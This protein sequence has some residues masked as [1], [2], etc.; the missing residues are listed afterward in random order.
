MLFF[1][2]EGVENIIGNGENAGYQ[3]LFLSSQCF[4][5]PS[6]FVKTRNCVPKG[7][8]TT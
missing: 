6:S 4:H 3:N 8:K 5:E 2:L 1:V 7:K